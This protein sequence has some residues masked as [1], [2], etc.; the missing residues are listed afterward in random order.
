[1]V[2]RCTNPN[3]ADWKDYG[4]RGI[5]VCARWRKFENFLSDMGE[6]PAGMSIDRINNDGPYAPDNCR[7]ATLRQQAANSRKVTLT[8]ADVE[9]VRANPNR[10]LQ[11]LAEALGV[12]KTTIGRI[13]RR[14]GRFQ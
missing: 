2:Q 7:W 5:T 11:E 3:S 4:G 14:E 13:R 9:W 10:T 8:D 6:R 1:M 12:G